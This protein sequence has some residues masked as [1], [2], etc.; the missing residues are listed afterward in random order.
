MHS[1][2]LNVMRLLTR[3][4]QGPNTGAHSV[5]L[6]LFLTS[7]SVLHSELI[8]LIYKVFATLNLSI[9]TWFMVT[10]GWDVRFLLYLNKTEI[11]SESGHQACVCVCVRK[12]SVSVCH[13]SASPLTP[14]SCLRGKTEMKSQSKG[15]DSATHL[16]LLFF[17]SH[18][19]YRR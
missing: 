1:I 8:L 12:V 18:S 3:M 7:F 4:Y 11:L 10:V 13:L 15:A 16:T 19:P 5:W 6:H 17:S 14:D 9:F 2:L